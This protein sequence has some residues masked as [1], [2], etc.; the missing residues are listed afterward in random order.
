LCLL[1]INKSQRTA[2][3][4]RIVDAELPGSSDFDLSE[5]LPRAAVRR[6]GGHGVAA[7]RYPSR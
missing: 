4:Q 2:V 7:P 5:H 6:T 3:H 1:L